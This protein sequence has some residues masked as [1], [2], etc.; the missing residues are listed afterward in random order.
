MLF[1]TFDLQR[2]F[3]VSPGQRVIVGRHPP[4]EPQN[5]RIPRVTVSRQV[6]MAHGD[7]SAAG[8]VPDE[9]QIDEG[10]VARSCGHQRS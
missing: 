7:S 8:C 3:L 10:R 1:E 5:V 2:L 4:P 6:R 9:A